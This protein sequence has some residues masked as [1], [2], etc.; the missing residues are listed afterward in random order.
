MLIDG[1]GGIILMD[2]NNEQTGMVYYVLWK[3]IITMAG[4]TRTNENRDGF[5]APG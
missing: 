2:A 5:V 3:V 1:G 4:L